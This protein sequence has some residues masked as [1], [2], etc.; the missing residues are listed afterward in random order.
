MPTIPF[1][2]N[3]MYYVSSE[4]QT[5]LTNACPDADS[6]TTCNKCKASQAAS[7]QFQ[8][9]QQK[10]DRANAQSSDAMKMYNKE[11]I[12]L[13]NF[14]MGIAILVYLIYSNRADIMNTVTGN[15]NTGSTATKVGGF[16]RRR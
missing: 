5:H 9:A 14:I 4:C 15:M 16:L 13:W 6:T 3:D 11:L 10:R 1:S 2:Q 7:K 12:T 8:D